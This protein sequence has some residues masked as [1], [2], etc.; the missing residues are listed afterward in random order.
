MAIKGTETKSIMTRMLELMSKTI[1]H[2]VTKMLLLSV[3]KV[4]MMIKS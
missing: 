4:L 3:L 1:Q 2:Y